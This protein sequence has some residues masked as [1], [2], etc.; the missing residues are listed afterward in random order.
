MGDF[1]TDLGVSIVITVLRQVKGAKKKAQFK[2]VFLKIHTL[3]QGVYGD[4]PDF[5]CAESE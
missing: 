2:K 3:I 1:Y 4:D 5:G